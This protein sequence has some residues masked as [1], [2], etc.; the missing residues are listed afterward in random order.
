MESCFTFVDI[1]GFLVLLVCWRFPGLQYFL[2]KY[3]IALLN[4]FHHI[5]LHMNG[6]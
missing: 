5:I 6:E 2:E 1:L 4:Y 3:V